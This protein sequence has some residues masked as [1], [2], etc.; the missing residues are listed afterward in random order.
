MIFIQDVVI[1]WYGIYGDLWWFLGCIFFVLEFIMGF[2]GD[3]SWGSRIISL[4]ETVIICHVSWPR[5]DP[6]D[7]AWWSIIIYGQVPYVLQKNYSNGHSLMIWEIVQEKRVIDRFWPI[8]PMRISD[9]LI[10][11]IRWTDG[12]MEPAQINSLTFNWLHFY[13]PSAP[14]KM[15]NAVQKY[16]S[17]LIITPGTLYSYHMF[18]L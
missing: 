1:W 10:L 12:P 13:F 8:T 18:P 11:R 7:P 5:N 4:L 3:T 9:S 6:D 17:T 14:K 15:G 16:E 2:H